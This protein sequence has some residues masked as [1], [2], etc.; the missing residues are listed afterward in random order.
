MV[1]Y[2]AGD[3]VKTLERHWQSIEDHT[4]PTGVWL[5]LSR[6]ISDPGSANFKFNEGVDTYAECK[7]VGWTH[8]RLSS[9]HKRGSSEGTGAIRDR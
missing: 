2:P 5:L 9:E 1:V 3:D 7:D 6:D 4:P 8:W